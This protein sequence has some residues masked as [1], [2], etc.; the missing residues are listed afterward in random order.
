MIQYLIEW[1]DPSV[2]DAP[3][4][5]AYGMATSGCQHELLFTVWDEPISVFICEGCGE[6]F[7]GDSDLMESELVKPFVEALGHGE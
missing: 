1:I 6:A 2:P 4:A 5:M 7:S 3:L